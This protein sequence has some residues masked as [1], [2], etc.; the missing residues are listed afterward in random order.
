MSVWSECYGTI[1]MTKD[2]GFS[3]R[4]AWE[5]LYDEVIVGHVEVIRTGKDCVSTEFRVSFSL[6]GLEAAKMIDQFVIRLMSTKGYIHSQIE[7]NI[8]FT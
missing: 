1:Q 8:R 7:S 5:S 4:K 6:E 3:V 2:S